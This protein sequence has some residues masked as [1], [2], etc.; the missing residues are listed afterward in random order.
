MLPSRVLDSI[1]ASLAAS[2]VIYS[3]GAVIPKRT[4]PG[5]IL[6]TVIVMPG[7][8]SIDSSIFRVKTNMLDSFR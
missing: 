4:L 6:T 2:P 7:P 5:P 8:I 1:D 3:L